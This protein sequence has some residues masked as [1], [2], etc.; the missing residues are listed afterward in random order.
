MQPAVRPSATPAELAQRQQAIRERLA[1]LEGVML[2]LS[3]TL[4]DRE[5]DKAQ[6]L[7]D[8]LELAGREQVRPRVERLVELLREGK[9]SEAD[10]DQQELLADLD[11][12]L[13][14]LT[15][16]LSDLDRRRAERE[17]LE[18]I[19]ATVRQ[20]LEEQIDLLTRTRAAE[21]ESGGGEPGETPA[22][23]DPDSRAAQIRRLAELEDRQAEL[24]RRAQGVEREMRSAESSTPNQPGSQQMQRAT[25]NMRSAASRLSEQNPADAGGEQESAVQELQS[26]L[27]E[28]DDALRQLRREEQEE[29][30]A[31]LEDRFRSLLE[32]QR[33]VRGAVQELA[34]RPAEKWDRPLQLRLAAAT[35]LQKVL[36]NDIG[37]VH[38]ILIDE[39]TT[40]V[41]PD[42][43]AQIRD[44]MSLV[45]ARLEQSDVSENTQRVI[46]DIIALLEQITEVIETRREQSREQGDQQQGGPSQ[47]QSKLLPASAELKLLRWSQVQINTRTAEIADA[48]DA[49]AA[50]RMAQLAER[51]ARLARWVERMQLEK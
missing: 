38:R 26:A 35:E 5:P 43:T 20:L 48:Q 50:A 13:E 27:D 47:Q 45:A 41:L 1:R 14:M 22:G 42:L 36:V 4:L 11:R 10:R 44:D 24:E 34:A 9:F 23:E 30:L 32:R 18:Q 37:A 12:L 51:Q 33:E 46:D 3:Q 21:A 16:T 29:T 19:K 7:N 17:R 28:L 8:A 40:A 2:K 6:R 49:A 15:S 39:G 25:E 31:A